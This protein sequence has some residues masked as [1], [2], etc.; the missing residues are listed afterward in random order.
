MQ[1]AYKRVC[2]V[3]ECSNG[4][5]GTFCSK[6]YWRFKKY[7]DP[8]KLTLNKHNDSHS[9]ENN[10]WSRMKA[11]CMNPNDYSYINYGGRGIKVCDRWLNSYN[12]FLRDMGRRPTPVHT[13]ERIDNNGD[14][15]PSNCKWAT[16]AEQATNKRG[17][18]NNT[19]GTPGVSYVSRD[20]LWIAYKW[21]NK[22]LT[23]IGSFKNK[24]D[25]VK[26]RKSYV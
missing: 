1:R 23:R 21:E 22:H 25:A 24:L 11:R 7:G 18:K 20:K 3:T 14:Y 26:A 10:T 13:I 2:T 19:S 5:H 6:H 15:K 16:R 8:N 17:Y 4:T 9:P 12:N